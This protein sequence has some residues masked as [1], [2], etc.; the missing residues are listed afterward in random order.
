MPPR[1]W[2]M[3]SLKVWNWFNSQQLNVLPISPFK[4]GTLVKNI[5]FLLLTGHSKIAELS[6]ALWASVC[7]SLPL[8]GLNGLAGKG[9][10]SFLCCQFTVSPDHTESEDGRSKL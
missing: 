7:Q 9:D 10:V 6:L 4:R 8:T 2:A 1:L 5:I 3:T